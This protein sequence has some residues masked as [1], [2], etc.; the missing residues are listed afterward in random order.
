M[1]KAAQAFGKCNAASV[2]TTTTVSPTSQKA[3]REPS[4]LARAVLSAPS[5]VLPARGP[6][7]AKRS[8]GV[9]YRCATPSRSHAARS[10]FRGMSMGSYDADRPP[11]TLRDN[12]PSASI[13]RP[14]RLFLIA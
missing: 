1:G 14:C 7:T 11:R 13:D 4:L 2:Q 5:G 8:P 9:V 6:A 10:S 12:G 3:K